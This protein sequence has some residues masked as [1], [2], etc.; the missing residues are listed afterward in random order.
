MNHKSKLWVV[1]VIV[2]CLII[3]G[4][5]FLLLFHSLIPRTSHGDSFDR[6]SGKSLDGSYRLEELPEGAQDF[7]YSNTAYGLGAYSYAA[8]TLSGDVYADYVNSFEAIELPDSGKGHEKIGQRVSE[9]DFRVRP[10]IDYVIDDSIDDYIIIYYDS[11]GG[12]GAYISAV[13][14]N[15]DTGRIV[16]MN[17]DSD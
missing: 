3:G 16:V 13:L 2:G 4:M 17:C 15:P 1:L 9:A 8:F 14:A 5:F 6:Y 12:S 11:W 10:G 7:R